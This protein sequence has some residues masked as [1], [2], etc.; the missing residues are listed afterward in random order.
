MSALAG[1]Q[2]FQPGACKTSGLCRSEVFP[3]T[4]IAYRKGSV[5]TRRPVAIRQML[6][7]AHTTA[8]GKPLMMLWNLK[9]FEEVPADYDA[10]LSGSSRLT[11][12]RL[13]R[14]AP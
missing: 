1:Y 4:V 2:A 7:E 14:P 5:P 12:P 6:T 11:R 13:G 10:Q 3:Q 8:A 9:G